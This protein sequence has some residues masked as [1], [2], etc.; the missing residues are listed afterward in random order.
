MNI[1]TIQLLILF[2]L[3]TRTA[4]ARPDPAT[5]HFF[6][7]PN[8]MIGGQ[9]I[10]FAGLNGQLQRA[11]IDKVHAGM[12]LLGFGL[13]FN[14]RGISAGVDASV[15]T[16]YQQ[17]VSATGFNSRLYLFVKAIKSA[18]WT[19]GPEIG[20]GWQELK[21][22]VTRPG[23]ATSFN[24]ALTNTQNQ[25]ELQHSNTLLDG[26]LSWMRRRTGPVIST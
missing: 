19:I 16:G 20:I 2:G 24:D 25:V 3:L 13:V 12:S 1:K 11:G 14:F 8:F 6:V 4:Y 9:F 17:D 23:A 10:N 5:R 21:V 22:Q 15:L 7:Q 18:N 26:A